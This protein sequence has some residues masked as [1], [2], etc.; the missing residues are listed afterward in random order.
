MLP[1][2]MARSL[3]HIIRKSAIM[4]ISISPWHTDTYL[5][6]CIL[7]SWNSYVGL[8]HFV[9]FLFAL[10]VTQNVLHRVAHHQLDL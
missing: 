2:R 1:H 7:F 5:D 9:P 6:V 10:N 3:H 8:Q 4:A